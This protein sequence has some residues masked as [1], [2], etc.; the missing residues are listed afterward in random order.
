MKICGLQKVTLLDFPGHVACTVF[1]GG[2]NFDC[3]FCYNSS[4]IRS[5][6]TPEVLTKE[7]FFEYLTHRRR[8]LDGVAISGGEPLLHKEI[9]EFIKNIKALGFKIKLDTNGSQPQR[10]KTLISEKLIDYVAMDIKNTFEKYPI[11]IGCEVDIS[12]IKESIDL[13]I[14]GS[15]DY[16]FRTTVVK[17]Y[18]NP[19]DFKIIGEMI[20]GAKRYFLQSYQYQDSVRNKTLNPMTKEE[21]QDCL[22]NI[23]DYVEYG[24]LREIE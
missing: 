9:L 18:H 10:L 3:P 12:K 8:I 2:C 23:K 24:A 4:L 21:L 17:E 11:T 22:N 1:L 6:Q 13:L 19:A 5:N 15:I 16:E 14:N 20:K 7:E